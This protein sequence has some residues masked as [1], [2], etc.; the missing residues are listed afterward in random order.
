M[1]VAVMNIR[2]MRVG[3]PHADMRMPV[4]VW[5]LASPVRVVVVLVMG[6]MRVGMLMGQGGMAMIM[7]VSLGQVQPHA[8]GHQGARQPEGG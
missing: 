3:V 1:P 5:F 6:V 4:V 2:K 7:A 8:T